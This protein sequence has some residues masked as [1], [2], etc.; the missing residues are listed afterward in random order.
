M[1]AFNGMSCIFIDFGHSFNLNDKI[2]STLYL[3]L[4]FYNDKI[5]HNLALANDCQKMMLKINSSGI[6]YLK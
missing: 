2:I 3:S 5:K 6:E 4:Y 1:A